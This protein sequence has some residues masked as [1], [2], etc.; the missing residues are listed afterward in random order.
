MFDWAGFHAVEEKK[1]DGYQST[2]GPPSS[3]DFQV[4]IFHF[5]RQPAER[6]Q[7]LS[8]LENEKMLQEEKARYSE[9]TSKGKK[10]KKQDQWAINREQNW[11][12]DT[13]LCGA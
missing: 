13:G 6:C 12:C 10:R 3:V 9:G 7:K 5:Y 4:S 8:E 11:A 2:S 1:T